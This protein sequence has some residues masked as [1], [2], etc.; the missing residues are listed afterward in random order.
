MMN[1]QFGEEEYL[2]KVKKIF[3]DVEKF[4][5]EKYRSFRLFLKTVFLHTQ[6]S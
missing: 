2:E 1:V 3:E 6:F 5:F 4:K